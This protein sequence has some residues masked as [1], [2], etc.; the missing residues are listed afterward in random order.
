MG[1]AVAA[2]I[3][4]VMVLIASSLLVVTVPRR[5]IVA[6]ILMAIDETVVA[7]TLMVIGETVVVGTL[8]TI[9]VF[10]V[11]V[12][13]GVEIEAVAE[14]VP[15]GV[16]SVFIAATGSSAVA[17]LTA[18]TEAT[19]RVTALTTAFT[20]ERTVIAPDNLAA[21]M[22]LSVERLMSAACS[23]IEYYRFDLPFTR[24]RPY[25]ALE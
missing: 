18:T 1:G 3:G 19:A 17:S 14:G 16:L 9:R 15:A 4:A 12:R 20:V 5:T 11:P 25:T 23:V 6:G 7:G 21:F 2:T 10:L 8:T 22:H 24:F 13:V